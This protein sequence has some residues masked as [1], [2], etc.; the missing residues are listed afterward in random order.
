LPHLDP[1]QAD[2]RLVGAILAIGIGLV[3][4]W[5][6]ARE[7]TGSWVARQTP[8]WIALGG[9]GWLAA[10]VWPWLGWLPIGLAIWLSIR[11]SWPRSLDQPLSSVV[12]RTGH[13]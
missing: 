1:S 10:G 6:F 12:R 9:A 4:S 8:L 13:G 3:A 5:I 11:S 7:R 2:G